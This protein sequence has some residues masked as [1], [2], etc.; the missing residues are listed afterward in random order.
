MIWLAVCLPVNSLFV[1][2][3]SFGTLGV[4]AA[5]VVSDGPGLLRL[6]DPPIGGMIIYRHDK[7]QL[8]PA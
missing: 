5:P 1:V 8:L 6:G 2:L 7:G 3:S 4:W